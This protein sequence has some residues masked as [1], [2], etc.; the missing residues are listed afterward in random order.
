MGHIT[1]SLQWVLSCLHKAWL[2]YGLAP[3][4]HTEQDAVEEESHALL[5][6]TGSMWPFQAARK[7]LK[8]S[9]LL[10]R[11]S[12]L[13]PATLLFLGSLSLSLSAFH[14]QPSFGYWLG[15][16]FTILYERPTIG[17]DS[18]GWERTHHPVLQTHLQEQLWSSEVCLSR[19]TDFFFSKPKMNW[20]CCFFFLK[21]FT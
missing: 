17:E 16:L 14:H 3:L 5:W 2:R 6:G 7:S 1:S 18:D 4:P 19:Q 8:T 20:D 12:S 21:I 9:R 11:N 10:V 15:P 13:Q